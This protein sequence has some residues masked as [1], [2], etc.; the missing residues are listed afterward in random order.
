M[1]AT[2]RNPLP[3]VACEETQVAGLENQ[4]PKGTAQCRV[5][6]S[7]SYQGHS[8]SKWRT[9]CFTDTWGKDNTQ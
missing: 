8:C 1:I 7:P 3:R 9:L 6:C 2:Q 4:N 5:A